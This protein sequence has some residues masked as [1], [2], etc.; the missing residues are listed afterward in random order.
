MSKA[1]I[2]QA[3]PRAVIHK[4]I[5]DVAET[6][7]DS[8]VEEIASEVPSANVDLVERVFDEYG[9]PADDKA[10]ESHEKEQFPKLEDLTSKQQEILR[11]IR[12]NPD[13]TQRELG[14][15]LQISAPTVSNHV[16]GIE[17]FEWSARYDFAKQVLDG[18]GSTPKENERFAGN[19]ES[20]SESD[21][22]GTNGATNVET[23]GKL[24]ERL[25]AIER[26]L[27]EVNETNSQ[28]IFRD[29]IVAQKVI[30][31]CMS[32]DLISE[33]EELEIIRDLLTES[34]THN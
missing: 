18:E 20:S 24:T 15:L 21:I 31:A 2:N 17:G 9:D 32:S 33:E 23:E 22:M 28:T 3:T 19:A 11:K 10:I 16:N 29:P 30:H 4:Q 8:S 12:E 1:T 5:L 34:V 26:E 13:A 14:E 25:T 7:P 27:K 6:Q